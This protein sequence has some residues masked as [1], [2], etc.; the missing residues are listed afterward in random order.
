M[1]DIQIRVGASLDRSVATVFNDLRD[2]AKRANDAMGADARRAA[3]D[4][5]AMR[6]AGLREEQQALREK[7]RAEERALR[8]TA[9]G[10]RQADQ[11]ALRETKQRIREEERILKEFASAQ[12]EALRDVERE[13]KRIDRELER[14]GR[15]MS[16]RE[17]RLATNIVHGVRSA[18]RFGL[19]AA[20]ELAEG[21]GVNLDFGRHVA[22][23]TDLE[24]TLTTVTNE[25]YM[26]NDPRNARRVGIGELGHEAFNIGNK[27]GTDVND[28]AAGFQEFVGKTGDLQTARETMG[29][30]AKIA[31]ATGSDFQDVVGAAAAI[32]AQLGDT[33][34]KAQAIMR[35]MRSIAAEGKV[36]AIP[37][38]EM[39][40]QMGK[41]AANA[42]RMEGGVEKNIATFGAIAQSAKLMGGASS[43]S[44]AATSIGSLMATFRSSRRLAEFRSKGVEIN[45]KTDPT[46]MR[47]IEDILV[48]SFKATQGKDFASSQANLSELFKTQQAA[49][50]VGGFQTIFSSA[51][52][53]AKGTE[54]EKLEEGAKAVRK[55]FERLSQT[56]GDE[57]LNESFNRAMNTS[58]SKASQFNNAM[59]DMTLSIQTALLPVLQELA[60]DLVKLS[61]TIKEF[62]GGGGAAA[63]DA[64]D[65]TTTAMADVGAANAAISSKSIS[66]TTQQ[67][68]VDDEKALQKS[69]DAHKAELAQQKNE[70]V[71]TGK[72]ALGLGAGF[73]AGGYSTY[74]KG[75]SGAFDSAG[76]FGRA[77]LNLT[78]V[79]GI[80]AGL[81]G[82][83]K[84]SE[85]YNQQTEAQKNQVGSSQHQIEREEGWLRQIHDSNKKVS[86]AISAG[87]LKVTIVK[88]ETNTGRTP[89]AGGPDSHGLT[90]TQ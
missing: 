2:T 31:K 19:H 46:K 87:S 4:E 39:A 5:A 73:L 49:K 70:G 26:P 52:G 63:N 10:K 32:N 64:A 37:M 6:R 18:G 78:P 21:A 50:A 71:S 27:T 1:S 36:G 47:N 86:D 82:A 72:R 68:N 3:R 54:Q 57:E 61:K 15:V 34:D 30:L 77:A 80:L 85:V 33:P 35:T 13:R 16:R 29:D 12:K 17:D 56:M 53:K 40:T 74:A 20:R 75:F 69:I 28:V 9:R 42:Q 48:D 90:P 14:R 24:K 7:A 60:P 62:F 23:N 79:G 22:A 81:G 11:Q 89:R 88:D 59:Q 44:N 66:K 43:G 8:E 83:G 55:E 38:R 67:K 65:A 41:L 25:G 45:S 76:G 51:Y 84:A 58:A